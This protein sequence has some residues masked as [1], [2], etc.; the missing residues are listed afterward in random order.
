VVTSSTP[1]D[2]IFYGEECS[3]T[4]G[5]QWAITLTLR[6]GNARDLYI[7]TGGDWPTTAAV[8][9]PPTESAS[10][11]AWP[12]GYQVQRQTGLGNRYTDGVLV[13][14]GGG[15]SVSCLFQVAGDERQTPCACV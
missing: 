10:P 4:A 11:S 9:I 7:D 15:C 1:Q 6:S 14:Q 8:G 13:R 5:S 2:S 3:S 12:A